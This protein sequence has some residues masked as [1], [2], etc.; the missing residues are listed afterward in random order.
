MRSFCHRPVLF[1]EFQKYHFTLAQV[2]NAGLTGAV[3]ILN[4]IE[5][6]EDLKKGFVL[7]VDPKTIF[8]YFTGE[9]GIKTR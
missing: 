5:N 8:R 6:R 7:L 3:K 2:F 9:I 4:I 1:L